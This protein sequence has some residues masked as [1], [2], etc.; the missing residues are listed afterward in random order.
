MESNR[1]KTLFD[2]D[3][4]RIRDDFFASYKMYKFIEIIKL[5]KL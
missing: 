4:V 2:N 5:K 1:K 3:L